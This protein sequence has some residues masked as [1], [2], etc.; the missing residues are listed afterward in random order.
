MLRLEEQ[1]TDHVRTHQRV[2]A[3]AAKARALELVKQV[4]LR[5]PELVLKRYPHQLSGGMKQ[6]IAIAI[7]LACEPRLLIADEP[8]TALDA[9]V[10]VE[11]VR[12]L[13]E[14][15][16]TKGMGIM[17]IT[18]DLGV[19]ASIADTVNVFQDGRVVESAPA[20][21]LFADPQHPY[22]RELLDAVPRVPWEIGSVTPREGVK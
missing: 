1:L 21:E 10:R 14:L 2:S 20:K 3:K 18:H 9:N 22:T 17:F 8:T 12:L 13:D 5:E 4:H 7:A 11:I 16:E 15:R 6:R 19:L